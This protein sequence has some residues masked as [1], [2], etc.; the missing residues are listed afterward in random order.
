M[1]L[2]QAVNWL[3]QQRVDIPDLRAIESG[4][5]FD[6]KTLIQAFVGNTP[7]ILR[8][9]TIPVTGISGPATSLQ[10]VVD[11]S[12]VWVPG[13]TNGSF[14]RTESGHANEVL[15][16]ANAKV[17]GSFSPGANFV[18][19][20]FKRATDP[21]TNDLVSVW[22]VDSQTEFT[23]TAP[24]GLV[25]DYEIVIDGSTFGNNAPI[26]IVTVSGSNVTK[27]KNA[28]QGLFR[29][30]T[31]GA[32]PNIS[33]SHTYA[34]NP[35]NNL[36]ATTN[37]SPDPFAG[38]DWELLTFKDWMDAVMTEFKNIKGSPFWYSPNGTLPDV[39]LT[40]LFFDLAG[41]KI[42]GKGA[43]Q[44]SATTPGELT[45]TSDLNLRSVFGKM[46]LVIPADTVQLNDLDVAYISLV[47]N[48]DF[49]PA[50]TFT[51]INGSSTV[52]GTL[53]I[54]GINNGDY[55]K[56]EAHNLVAWTKVANVSGTTIT[57]VDPYPGASA[58]G[59]ALRTVASYSVSVASPNNVPVSGN[60]YWLAKRDDNAFSP[61]TIASAGSSG[62]T[63]ASDV[64]TLITTTPHNLVEGQS[65]AIA[66]ASDSTF[67][68]TFDVATVVDALTITY[69]NPGADVG[70]ATAGGGTLS[71]IA[72]I[73]L[74]MGAGVG[75]LQQGEDV[76][77]DDETTLNILKF[78]G[79]E[80]ETDTT[81][82]YTMFPNG[83][84]PYTFT[85]N[86]N[87]T[88]AISALAGNLN[89]I[90]NTLDQPAYAEP[91]AV[92]GHVPAD[93]REITG[94]IPAGSTLSLPFNSR[95]GD[96]AQNYTVGKGG[97]ELF[98]NGQYL[99]LSKGQVDFHSI[100]KEYHMHDTSYP[101]EIIL[102]GTLKGGLAIKFRPAANCNLSNIKYILTRSVAGTGT[103][104]VSAKVRTS[105]GSVPSGTTLGTSAS[106]PVSSLTNGI[107]TAVD[108]VFSTTVALTGGVDYWFAI[109]TD[110]T[111]IAANGTGGANIHV[112]RV[113]TGITGTTPVDFINNTGVTNGTSHQLGSDLSGIIEGP[114]FVA[115]LTATLVTAQASLSFVSGTG[116]VY[117]DL[118]SI[119]PDSITNNPTMTFIETAT[120]IDITTLPVTVLNPA[121]TT[122]TFSGLTTLNSGTKYVIVLRV[123]NVGG[124]NVQSN[125]RLTGTS[126]AG[127]N[128]TYKN[129]GTDNLWHESAS[130]INPIVYSGDVNVVASGLQTTTT[131]EYP[132]ATANTGPAWTA[133]TTPTPAFELDIFTSNDYNYDWREVGVSLS[134]SS[135]IIILQD[136]V[137][138]DVL[139]FRLSGPGGPSGG[140]GAPDDD[141]HNLPATVTPDNADEIP[142]WDNSLSA[143]RKMTRGNFLAGLSGLLLVNTYASTHLADV[144]TDDII[145]MNAV[146]GALTV[147]L[148][149]AA[150]AAGK[151]FYIKKT[152]ASGNSVTIDASGGETIDGALTV[153]LT[154]QYQSRTI[155]SDGTQWWI[156]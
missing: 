139:S 111:Y 27:I 135:Q 2:K 71:S 67:N 63:R 26:A 80:N 104:S 44:H 33:Y 55:I 138:G 103:G 95:Q 48:Q 10:L 130:S 136:L 14:L 98:L 54:T 78:I 129:T 50:N 142:I 101:N 81:P 123:D 87:L 4:V 115:G 38:G 73:Y 127:A 18:S 40:D 24:R 116:N 15:S 30:G 75:E 20:R 140:G 84:A 45:W 77:I 128:L 149:S 150:S 119:V 60:T 47:R 9:F 105:S 154:T 92:V 7:Y 131:G 110:A 117:A 17:V 16:P 100:L 76:Q 125:I 3:G 85:S 72:K 121:L 83:L 13:D 23:K 141:F 93:T 59:K 86:N 122:F 107:L 43:W 12:V 124:N 147:N 134:N 49:Q 35:E 28:K 145:L 61:L 118:Y 1:A 114:S 106:F 108:F 6:F 19:I 137:I 51:F 32:S 70:A 36:E 42:T 66:G 126:P 8:G 146:G 31:G 90:F 52:T 65:F 144:S 53:N 57:L 5:I 152:D 64:T 151:V 25:M 56:Y 89:A 41:S 96:I 109:E 155:V 69:Y 91:L 46:T 112:E 29:L 39:N 68:G 21:T 94:P 102:T 156:I 113:N 82:P 37:S 99:N 132:V 34:V 22:D 153:A 120:P 62:L 58:S 79:A 74:R 143:Y 133:Q 97:L 148:P 11:S 88:Q